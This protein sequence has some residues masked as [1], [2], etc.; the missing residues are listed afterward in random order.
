MMLPVSPEQ[1]LPEMQPIISL[2]AL[3]WNLIIILQMPVY[4]SLKNV[5]LSY[6]LP[7]TVA[8]KLKM[9]QCRLLYKGKTC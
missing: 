8:D 3:C 9:K 5:A 4:P 2:M 1:V 6:N 7:A